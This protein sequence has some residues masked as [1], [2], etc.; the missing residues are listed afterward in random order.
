MALW[1]FDALFFTVP[2]SEVIPPASELP[3]VCPSALN[4]L[5][6]QRNLCCQPEIFFFF[7]I[8]RCWREEQGGEQR[9]DLCK[10]HLLFAELQ[11]QSHYFQGR[12]Q[13]RL[14][15]QD[16]GEWGASYFSCFMCPE[17]TQLPGNYVYPRYNMRS[18]AFQMDQSV[19]LGEVKLGFS[20]DKHIALLYFS[21]YEL[22]IGLGRGTFHCGTFDGEKKRG[23]N[24]SVMAV[25]ILFH[26]A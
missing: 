5:L 21:F 10:C 11:H 15:K 22:Y 13:E 6:Q 26:K 4:K 14:N 24:E 12:K 19:D 7:I 16:L 1:L 8:S 3:R 25:S 9:A 18:Q 20:A 2:A 17:P 23:G